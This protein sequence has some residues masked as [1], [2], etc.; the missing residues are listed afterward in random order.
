MHRTLL[1]TDIVRLAECAATGLIERH[2]RGE[3][4]RPIAAAVRCLSVEGDPC[5]GMGIFT[6]PR[7]GGLKSTRS[8]GG[9]RVRIR[10]PPP[11]SLQTLGRSREIRV[12]PEPNQDC[13]R[14]SQASVVPIR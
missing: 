1:H 4:N 2:K 13:D 11:A 14:K 5:G 7:R 8:Y 9:P 12:T 6:E 3:R 10:F